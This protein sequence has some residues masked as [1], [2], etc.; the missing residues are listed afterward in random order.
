MRRRASKSRQSPRFKSCILTT[1]GNELVHGR[2]RWREAFLLFKG[3]CQ[4]CS[5]LGRRMCEWI[6]NKRC[7][8][9]EHPVG[10]VGYVGEQRLRRVVPRRLECTRGSSSAARMRPKPQGREAEGLSECCRTTVSADCRSADTTL[11]VEDPMIVRLRLHSSRIL[12]FT[13]SSRPFLLQ[14]SPSPMPVMRTR[15]AFFSVINGVPSLWRSQ[16]NASCVKLPQA[17]FVN[18]YVNTQHSRIPTYTGHEVLI[19]APAASY[20]RPRAAIHPGP[21][22]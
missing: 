19:P 14:P 21:C 5:R 4:A 7:S 22:S 10:S 17:P 18:S 1:V 11:R 8:S 3:L 2:T 20:R 13:E 15:A 6:M 16:L 9:D 12:P